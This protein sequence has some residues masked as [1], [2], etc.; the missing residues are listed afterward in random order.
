MRDYHKR[1]N[2][3]CKTS[4]HRFDSDRRLWMYTAR[5]WRERTLRLTG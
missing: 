2:E 1:S 4:I 5:L 3:N